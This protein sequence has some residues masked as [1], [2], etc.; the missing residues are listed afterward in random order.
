MRFLAQYSRPADLVRDYDTQVAK[1]GLF[2]R[3]EPPADLSLYQA[4]EV[5]VVGPRGEQVVLAGQ[6]VQV[7]PGVGLA[8]AFPKPSP[9]LAAL[10]EQQRRAGDAPG[11]PPVHSIEGAAPPQAPPPEDPQPGSAA[12]SMDKIQL[13]LHGNRDER[14]MILKDLNKT[15]HPFVLRNPNLQIEEVLTA[16]KLTTVNP[17]LLMGIANKREWGSRADIASALVRNP[18]TPIGT[19]IK[20]LDNVSQGELRLLAKDPRAKT[21]IA[22]AARKKLFGKV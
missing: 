11:E 12:A 8:V 6:I 4:A 2:L 15:L 3:L 9:E 22:Q 21:P 13:A 17:E 20:L 10:V 16:A 19:A 5:V 7:A 18:N 14:M 1:G